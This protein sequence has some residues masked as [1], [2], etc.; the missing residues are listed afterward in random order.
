MV[1]N[2]PLIYIL[3]LL[4]L[5]I[6]LRIISPSAGSNPV[7][8]M[9]F[10]VRLFSGTLKRASSSAV[11]MPVRMSFD[12]ALLPKSRFTALIMMDLPAPVSPLNTERPPPKV[13]LRLSI[14]A[15]FFIPSSQSITYNLF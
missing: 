8:R 3:C 6:I 7:F 11:S 5:E 1:D 2:D 15:K 13:I 4:L 9:I 14:I 12:D 10:A